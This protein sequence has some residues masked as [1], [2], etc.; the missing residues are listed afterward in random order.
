M[1]TSFRWHANKLLC[2]G[3]YSDDNTEKVVF[4]SF[5]CFIS[6]SMFLVLF[7]YGR[8]YHVVRQHNRAIVPSLQDANSQEAI[9]AREIK[10]SR[11]LFAAAFGFCIS[12][13]PTILE[14]NDFR[15]LFWNL[16]SY[17]YTVDSCVVRSY[18]CVDQPHDLWRH[19]SSHVKRDSKYIILSERRLGWKHAVFTQGQTILGTSLLRKIH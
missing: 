4:I 13:I 18:F 16:Y 8:V 15:V 1:H 7:C 6:L 9:R 17:R 5:G 12:W 10:T 19:E 3:D 11:I 2:K 14:S